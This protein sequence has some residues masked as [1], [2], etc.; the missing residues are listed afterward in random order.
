MSMRDGTT[1]RMLYATAPLWLWAG[2]WA[3]MYLLAAVHA[4][5]A[6]MIVLSVLAVGAAGALLWHATRRRGKRSLHQLA[7]AAN[8][9][10]AAVGIVWTCVPLLLL[11][12][13]A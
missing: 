6:G 9:V 5:R 8:A 12:G 11:P 10:L 4:G 7:L 1:R 2:H 13:G 3:L